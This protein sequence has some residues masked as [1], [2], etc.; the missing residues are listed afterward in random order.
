MFYVYV[1]RSKKDRLNYIGFTVDLQRRFKEHNDGKSKS[2]AP[3]RPFELLYYE[4]HTSESDA[5]RR[6]KYLKTSKGKASLK[7]ILRCALGD[8]IL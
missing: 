6:E 8:S 7:Q 2:T 1:L 4:A 3:R 5:R